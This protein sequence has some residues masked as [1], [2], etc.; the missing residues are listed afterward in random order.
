EAYHPAVAFVYGWALLVV[1]QSGGMAAVAVTFERYLGELVPGAPSQ[2]VAAAAMLALLTA[3]NCLGVRPGSAVPNALM[4][5]K[6]V[7]LAAVG[8][9]G[10]P[11]AGRAPEAP[12]PIASPVSFDRL[13]AEAAAL[14]PVLFAY[15]GWQ[16]ASFVAGEMKNPGKDL[17]RGLLLGVL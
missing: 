14:T 8:V 9:C 6:I 15:G 16:T 1:I 4:L 12:T 17:P 5:C 13:T 2:G 11:L 10:W 3:V 7:A